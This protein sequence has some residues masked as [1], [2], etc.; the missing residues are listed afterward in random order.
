MA[1]HS[2][3]TAQ[4]TPHVDQISTTTI[5]DALRRRAQSVINDKSINAESRA[6]IRYALEI[7]DPWL[8][9][10]VRR[11][12]ESDAQADVEEPL[13]RLVALAQQRL[14][15]IQRLI[16]DEQRNLRVL[17][18]E[19]TLPSVDLSGSDA[20]VS[21]LLHALVRRHVELWD[22][23]DLSDHDQLGIANGG[24]SLDLLLDLNTCLFEGSGLTEEQGAGVRTTGSSFGS[25]L[26]SAQIFFTVSTSAGGRRERSGARSGAAR[27]DVRSSGFGQ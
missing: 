21:A 2:S 26:D 12:K 15:A 14:A 7:N 4:E 22:Q 8:A 27:T 6:L 20:D 19:S 11:V 13:P 24:R 23:D 9:E 3:A 10:L 16:A 25:G 5:S 18:R 17:I 1:S